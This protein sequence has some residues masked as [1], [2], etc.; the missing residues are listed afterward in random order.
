[1]LQQGKGEPFAQHRQVAAAEDLQGHVLHG[2]DI[3]LDQPGIVVGAGA[4]GPGNQDHQLLVHDAACANFLSLRPML[5]QA[6]P[7]KI[8]SMPRKMPS[9]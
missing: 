9:V 4:V 5:T 6:A 1:M 2:V 7:M 3:A 8:R